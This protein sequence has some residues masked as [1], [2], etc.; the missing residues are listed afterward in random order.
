MSISQPSSTQQGWPTTFTRPTS[1]LADA[2]FTMDPELGVPA[3][4]VKYHVGDFTPFSNVPDHLWSR[5]SS[6]GR[7]VN[8]ANG[9]LIRDDTPS[10]QYLALNHPNSPSELYFRYYLKLQKGYQ[11]SSQGKKLPGLAGR[12]GKWTGTDTNG[13]YAPTAG[14]GGSPTKGTYDPANGGF[15]GWSL[16]HHAF[17]GP[18]D[19]N[20]YADLVPL[21]YYA[22]HAKMT[23]VFGEMWRWGN[24][25]TGFVNLEQDRWYCIEH[26]AKVNDVVGP[27]D[28]NGNGTAVENGVVRGWIDGVMVFEKTNAVLRKHPAIK[29]DEVWLDH[30]HGGTTPAEAEHPLQMAALVVAKNYIGPMRVGTVAPPPPGPVVIPAWMQGLPL[31]Q[32]YAIPGTELSA[33]TDLAAQIA[34]GL[35]NA[36]LQ[37][38]GFGK[39]RQGIFDFSGG[40]LKSNGSE[41][42]VFG[43][44]GAGAWAGNDVRGLRLEDDLPRWKTRTKP[45]PAAQ[46]PVR[47]TTTVVGDPTSPYN[48]N[49]TP[50]ARHS[51]AHQNFIDA[52][53]TFMTFSCRFV[54]QTDQGQYPNVDSI[55]L[56]SGLWKSTGDAS[57]NSGVYW[58]WPNGRL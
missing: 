51:Y 15:S 2:T 5:K 14:N 17:A 3:L 44:G 30:Y 34:A 47:H 29:I 46:I 23:D 7:S 58:F 43:G 21:N 10:A 33:S 56:S 25:T 4:G 12:Y 20:P 42:L 16:R 37:P 6:A 9:S 52:T 35:T 24:P 40:T 32:W 8:P 1:Q 50:V 36:A 53:N 18:T 19:A 26:Y 54:W 45:A 48:K 22:Y 27:F 41:M 49:D 11:C 38:I 57:G 28:V 39:P 13:Y 55:P 31:N